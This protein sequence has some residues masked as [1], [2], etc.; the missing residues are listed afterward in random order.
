MRASLLVPLLLLAAGCNTDQGNNENPFGGD[1]GSVDVGD[2]PSRPDLPI[3]QDRTVPPDLVGIDGGGVDGGPDTDRTGPTIVFVS[4]KAG[5]IVGGTFGIDVTIAD[6]SGVDDDSVACTFGASEANPGVPVKL[7]RSGAPTH[8]TGSVNTRSLPDP[9]YVLPLISVTARDKTGDRDLGN[10]N[11]SA[12]AE[13]VIIDNVGPSVDLDPPKM[14]IV[15]ATNN[16][17][18]PSR[19][20]D[21]VGDWAANDG[22]V[23]TQL[24]FFR[25]RIEDH[26]NYAPGERVEWISKVRPGSVTLYVSP[27]SFANG[28]LLMH[29]PAFPKD[30]ICD[31]IN[32]DLLPTLANQRAGKKT[33][34]A[35]DLVQIPVG[36][37]ADYFPDAKLPPL[38]FYFRGMFYDKYPIGDP[39]V[40]LHPKPV[41]ANDMLVHIGYSFNFLEP[42]IWTVPAVIPPPN[43]A[44]EGLQFDF[45]NSHIPEGPL[46]VAVVA[47]DNAGN[48]S[49]SAPL[50]VCYDATGVDFNAPHNAKCSDY[51]YQNG[52]AAE[53][54]KLPSCTLDQC[55]SGYRLNVPRG[56]SARQPHY[57]PLG[58]ILIVEG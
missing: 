56:G 25:A 32:P 5:E 2:G 15:Q 57:S 12:V 58:D 39:Q 1:D 33:A 16:K 6:P 20:F 42:S 24:Q 44:C 23:V 26:G 18:A 30:T 38:S 27:G 49:V 54:G 47:T 50:R 40:M 9:T 31:L 43:R 14:W 19:P 36:G 21:P 29:D 34:T 8:F 11:P 22:D 17:V 45:A 35:V 55:L 10:G 53:M 13:T 7:T 3:S 51:H 41:C 37:G 46:C 48:H 28:G 4:P 52:P